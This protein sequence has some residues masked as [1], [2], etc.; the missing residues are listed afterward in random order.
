MGSDFSD[1][2]QQ[3]PL[4]PIILLVVGFAL[5]FVLVVYAVS[6]RRGRTNNPAPQTSAPSPSF[7][8]NDD[9][10]DLD[11]LTATNE[12]APIRSTRSEMRSVRLE[13]GGSVEAVEVMTVLRDI[14]TGELIVQIGNKAYRDLSQMND[15]EVA[16]RFS[17]A[18]REL[19]KSADVPQ[20]VSAAITEPA[21]AAPSTSQPTIDEPVNA[22]T[23]GQPPESESL[24]PVDAPPDVQPEAPLVS[25]P[26]RPAPK[27]PAPRKTGKLPGDL[28][29]YKL[30]DEPIIQLG[31]ILR[32]AKKPDNKPIPDIDIAG[33]IEAFIQH[34]LAYTPEYSER[35]IHVHPSPDGGVSIEV[36]GT[37]FETVGEVSDTDVRE[38]LA[39]TI[40]EWQ[41]RH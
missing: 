39:S 9:L 35:S 23:M 41:D 3:I 26:A 15:A 37:Y 19:A 18:I 21:N 31:N 11:V 13:E 32:R 2:L 14:A 5:T 24:A 16:R 28:P 12:P 36:D 1:F 20:P 29:S 7:A 8:A 6:T 27:S 38:F 17:T 10:P 30:P 33:A 25:T 40:Q 22:S 34:K 4:G